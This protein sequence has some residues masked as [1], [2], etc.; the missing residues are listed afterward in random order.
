MTSM[1]VIRSYRPSIGSVREP[2]RT[3][4]RTAS[5]ASSTATSERSKPLASTPRS[6]SAATRKPLAHPASSTV[7]GASWATMASAT[8]VKNWRQFSSSYGIA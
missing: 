5:G 7:F 3:W 4:S 6:R 8:P 1:Q 2:T